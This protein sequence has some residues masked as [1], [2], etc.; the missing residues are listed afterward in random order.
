MIRHLLSFFAALASTTLA[1]RACN[2]APHLCNTSYDQITHLGAHDS[3]FLRDTSTGFSSFGNQYLDSVA[4]LDAG[5][6]LLSAQIHI[7]SNKTTGARELHLCHSS[8]GMFDAGRLQDWL[9]KIRAWMDKN[10][11]EVVTLLLVNIGG[12]DATELEG[13][14]A[15]ADLARLGYIP[16]DVNK[17]PA[18]SNKTVTT[19][20]SLGDMIGKGERLVTFVNPLKVD[21]ENAPYLVNEFDFVWENAYD[22]VDGKDFA[23]EPDRP[24]NQSSIAEMRDSGRLFLMNHMLY[25]QQAFG[26]Q[27]PDE[28][29][30]NETNSWSGKGGLGS[31]LLKCGNELRRQPTFVLVDFFN[32]GPA[33]KTVDIFNKVQH[34]VGRLDTVA[35]KKVDAN[36]AGREGS[37]SLAAVVALTLLVYMLA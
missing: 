10:T 34:P 33:I 15:K 2:N 36:A 17:A 18:L 29:K 31:H 20:P 30:I 3:P 16:K 32:V 6:R 13:E 7:A 37:P 27:I 26:I 5:V 4:Q 25:W 35:R 9:S 23:C 11:N 28:R 21:K 22:V 1:Q 24:S 14:Y 12:V 19:W 8:C